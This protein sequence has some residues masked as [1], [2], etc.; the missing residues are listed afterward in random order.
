M[1]V[2]SLQIIGAN[3]RPLPV[4]CDNTVPPGAE[5]RGVQ[6]HSLGSFLIFS[7]SANLCSYLLSQKQ[8]NAHV[9]Y[10]ECAV[11]LRHS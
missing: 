8:C 7:F 4:I 9:L 10:P 2:V 1:V 6:H 11:E 3:M 5:E